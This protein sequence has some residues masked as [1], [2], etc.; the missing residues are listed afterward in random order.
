LRGRAKAK[1]GNMA[2]PPVEQGNECKGNYQEMVSFMLSEF[3]EKDSYSSEI[4]TN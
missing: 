3:H 4:G 1:A 2:E